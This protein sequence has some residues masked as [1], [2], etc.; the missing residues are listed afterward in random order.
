MG[1]LKKLIEFCQSYIDREFDIAEFQNRLEQIFLP[2][3]FKNTLE[4]KQHN[5]VNKLEEIRFCFLTENQY[6]WGCQVAD[7]LKQ[8]TKYHMEKR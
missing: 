4:K 3:R 8:E 5:A 2:D 6:K 1:N 7:Y